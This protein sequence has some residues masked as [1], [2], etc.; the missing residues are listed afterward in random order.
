MSQLGT[1]YRNVF[2]SAVFALQ[3]AAALATLPFLIHIKSICSKDK[4]DETI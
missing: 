3:N 1:H 2:F 4:R